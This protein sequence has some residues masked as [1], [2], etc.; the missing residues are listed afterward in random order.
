MLPLT[1]TPRPVIPKYRVGLIVWLACFL[2][3]GVSSASVFAMQKAS[4]ALLTD[5]KARLDKSE[6]E[7]SQF[8]AFSALKA[9]VRKS[10]IEGFD[11]SKVTS[12][13]PAIKNAIESGNFLT[14]TALIH[15]Q[16]FQLSVQRISKQADT[17]LGELN[18]GVLS[19][20]VKEGDTPLVG[21]VITLVLSGK[22]V[23]QSTTGPSGGYTF[24]LDAS[25]Y[26]LRTAL[27]GYV[28]VQVD[29]QLAAQ[30]AITKDI[31]LVKVPPP[32][33]LP[34]SVP[35]SQPAPMP[36][37]A[38]A[39]SS[40]NDSTAYSTYSHT[41][42]QS[43]SGTFTADIMT[44][45]LASGHIRVLEDTANDGDCPDNCSVQSVSS[46]VQQD[47][48]FAGINGS[49]FC[50]TAYGSSCA[51]KT[52]SFYW[53]QYNSRLQKMINPGNLLGEQ[54]PFLVFDASG[55]G[56]FLRHWVDYK[57]SGIALYAGISC[58]PA[59]VLN[60]QYS[61][62]ESTLDTKQSTAKISRGAIGLKGQ[63]LYVVTVQGAT[64][65]DLGHVIQALGVDNAVNTDAGGSSGMVYK[66]SYKLGPGR[67]VP[68]V[69]VFR[70]Q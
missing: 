43:L 8:K 63:T 28:P 33:V 15:S 37:T 12:E 27:T 20:I 17:R 54:D 1:P 21:V 22:T 64:V 7:A 32:M 30:Q 58:T 42:V 3:I 34:V 60:G 62:D 14:A 40:S 18:K 9:D 67:A 2:L 45:N 38:P 41:S 31:E 53:K 35:A 61:V 29:I 44:F 51:G 24:T 36:T 66:N 46:F 59:V 5:Q 19:G 52:N 57:N 65:Q 11:V 50:P 6:Q 25:T 49:Y 39:F 70:E 16:R 48:G 23:A 26:T 56:T 10:E 69:L 55:H 4:S 47:G 68:N 13:Y